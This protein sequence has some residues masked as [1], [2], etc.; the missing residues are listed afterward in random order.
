MSSGSSGNFVAETTISSVAYGAAAGVGEG[1]GG[2]VGA[3]AKR[4]DVPRASAANAAAARSEILRAMA[5]LPFSKFGSDRG[6]GRAL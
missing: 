6:R 1:A 5:S 3:C 2:C 4:A